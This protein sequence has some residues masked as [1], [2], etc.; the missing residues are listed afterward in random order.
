MDTEYLTVIKFKQCRQILES[1]LK[2]GF[3]HQ[4][5]AS[6]KAKM[7]SLQKVMCPEG[8]RDLKLEQV[9]QCIG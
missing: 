3:L 8:L 2:T 9:G 5:L 7:N 6:M 4:Y 1:F